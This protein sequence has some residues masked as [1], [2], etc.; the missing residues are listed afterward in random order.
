MTEEREKK[1]LVF[2]ERERIRDPRFPFGFGEVGG[3]GGEEG[4]ERKGEGGEE[5]EEGEVWGGES[6]GDGE[7]E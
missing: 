4:E 2:L 5:G 1:G 7:G 3:E 6:E